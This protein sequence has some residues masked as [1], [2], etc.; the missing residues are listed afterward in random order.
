MVGDVYSPK[1]G[2]ALVTLKVK[3]ERMEAGDSRRKLHFIQFIAYDE[4]A[5]A[6]LENAADG[7]IV[8]VQYHLST[9]GRKD[10]NGVS[11]F[12]NNRTVDNAVFGQVLGEEK[13]SVP[14]AMPDRRMMIC[15]AKEPELWRVSLLTLY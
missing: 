7:R 5:E 3:S 14:Y 6:F 1:E 9:N 4:W 13:V 11:H 15:I 12:F 2:I 8:Y 10:E